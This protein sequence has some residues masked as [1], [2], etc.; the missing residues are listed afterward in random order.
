MECKGMTIELAKEDFVNIVDKLE[1]NVKNVT[2]DSKQ[3]MNQR[4]TDSKSSSI[5]LQGSLFKRR[6][7]VGSWRPR[8]FVL[9]DTFLQYYVDADNSTPRGSMDVIGCSI[10][11]EQPIEVDEEIYYPF[12]ITSGEN[13]NLQYHLATD[14][15]L[16]ADVW[17]AKILDVSYF[18]ELTSSKSGKFRSSSPL[19]SSSSSSGYMTNVLNP[20]ETRAFLPTT[21]TIMLLDRIENH[22][23]L[24]YE[25]LLQQEEDVPNS[26]ETINM[27]MPASSN[28]SSSNYQTKR[29]I[30]N[31]M[32]YMKIESIL[33]YNILHIASLLLQSSAR[34]SKQME[35]DPTKQIQETL[36]T[37]SNHTKIEYCQYRTVSCNNM[38]V[39][40]HI[41]VYCV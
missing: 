13:K 38:V 29:K 35:L 25:E 40:A 10:S 3:L 24:L 18:A 12:V 7:Y 30:S 26:W 19:T 22:I 32:I 5:R 16:D 6:D 34:S 21:P 27:T 1:P 8:Y 11:S 4:T 15:K 37:F 20:I 14:N 17:V 9:K 33:P 23:Q 28:I 2:E 39:F 41:M 36:K 31:T